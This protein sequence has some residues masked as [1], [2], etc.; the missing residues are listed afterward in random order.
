V[1]DG[2]IHADHQVQLLDEICSIG[3]IGLLL[4]VIEN[5]ASEFGRKPLNLQR[6]E[7]AIWYLQERLEQAG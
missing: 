2:R 4:T 3:E 7:T 1:G 6:M 5:V